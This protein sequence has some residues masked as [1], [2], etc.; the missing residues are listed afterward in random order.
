MFHRCRQRQ[1]D[2]HGVIVQVAAIILFIFNAGA[3]GNGLPAPTFQADMEQRVA[4]ASR[5][6]LPWDGP[7]TGP[8]GVAGKKIAMV[9]EDLRNGGIL[10]VA[11]GVQEAAHVMEWQVSVFDAGGTAEGKDRAAANA[12]AALPDGLILVGA[13]ANVMAPR[14]A[15]L[16]KRG[17]PMVGW[18]VGPTA[19]PMAGNPVAV[20][21][22]T[23]PLEVA[24]ITALAAVV[25][26]GGKAG[27]VIFT[28]SNF[29]IA[30]TKANAMAEVIR[31]CEGCTLLEI[32]DVAISRSAGEVPGVIRELLSR[33]GNKWTHA[34]AINDIY[35]DYAVPELIKAGEVS[36]SISFLSAGD[37]SPSAFIRIQAGVF[38]TGTV[39]EPLNVHGWQ[40]VDELNRLM[41]QEPVSGYIAPV[42]LVTPEN[43]LYDN[44]PGIQYDPDNGYRD[45]YRN[46]WK[47]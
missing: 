32:R 8:S 22:S 4:A 25:A 33:H 47:R 38:Q 3:Y 29:E 15:P 5:P 11:K 16:A 26:S 35:F 1:T 37:G 9:C 17:V 21:I 14:L 13:D 2:A 20:N 18:H 24:R 30:S 28:D 43:I 42:H 44:K 12:L 39:A 6:N 45:I 27:V 46:I 31:S 40:L 7:I 23:N 34:L 19:G 36:R 41:A 10:G